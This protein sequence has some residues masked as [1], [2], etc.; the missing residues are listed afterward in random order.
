[1]REIRLLAGMVLMVA[2]LAGGCAS[3]EQVQ[4]VQQS[5]TYWPLDSLALTYADPV[6]VAPLHDHPLRWVAFVVNPWGVVM[7]YTLNRPLYTLA[8][9]FPG[10][11]GFTA[12]DAGL[13]AQRPSLFSR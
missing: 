8:S 5:A 9:G 12:E 10:L 11:F 1:M 6:A 3:T 4:A 7:D 13:H 2:L